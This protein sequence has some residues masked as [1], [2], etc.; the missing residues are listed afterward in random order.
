MDILE[1]M[2][3]E[4]DNI[5]KPHFLVVQGNVL[6]TSASHIVFAVNYATKDNKP[7]KN[8]GGFAGQVAEFI[9]EVSETEYQKGVPVSFEYGGKNYHALP[10][11]SNEEG[12][13][14]EAPE[15]IETCLN[16]LDVPDEEI[17]ATVLI[18]AGKAGSDWNANARNIAGMLRSNKT[19][20][21]Y[22]LDQPKVFERI[23]SL[24]PLFFQEKNEVRR[25][26][27][28]EHLMLRA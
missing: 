27:K 8:T 20:G 17:I 6:K 21:L 22:L 2:L 23:I 13:W 18:G 11:H 25:I 15:L 9:P 16:M 3:S 1:F 14:D 4:K 28:E 5:R 26:L 12:G 24:T 7:G 10:V 19:L